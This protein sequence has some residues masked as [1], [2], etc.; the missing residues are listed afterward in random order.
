MMKV[1]AI[2]AALAVSV[3]VQAN[4][5]SDYIQ[6]EISG[7]YSVH[8]PGLRGQPAPMLLDYADGNRLAVE[9]GGT[10]RMMPIHDVNLA[11]GTVNLLDESGDLVTL[12]VRFGHGKFVYSSGYQIGLSFV[13]RLTDIDYAA[14]R[15]V[16]AVA[17]TAPQPTLAT[18]PAPESQQT[19]TPEAPTSV[20]VTVKA[21]FDCA[22]AS[23]AVEGM[24]CGNATLAELDLRTAET[25]KSLRNAVE[26]PGALKSE[27]IDWLKET[28]NACK[29]L[30]CLVDAY[31]TRAEDLEQMAQYFSK[32]AEF[33]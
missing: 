17:P 3:C 22:K 32:P 33:R 14:M 26:D 20:P 28:R 5:A 19:A 15:S 16:A 9:H 2:A 27:Q 30:D 21:S 29:T 25:Y 4:E 6:Q 1:V 31:T 11:Q 23:T 13:R 18:L 24:I 7:V 12:S 10:L 8:M